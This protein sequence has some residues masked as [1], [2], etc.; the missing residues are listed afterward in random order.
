MKKVENKNGDMKDWQIVNIAGLIKNNF[1]I[2]EDEM[3]V[4]IVEFVGNKYNDWIQRKAYPETCGNGGDVGQ[5]VFVQASAAR[6]H[7]LS[8]R[9]AGDCPGRPWMASST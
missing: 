3:F 4:R 7:N 8:A 9:C 2:Y 6:I 1:A 5:A